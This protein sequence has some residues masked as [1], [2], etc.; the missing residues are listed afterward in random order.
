MREKIEIRSEYFSLAESLDVSDLRAN[1]LN[2]L[3][4]EV[5]G[6]EVDV[7]KILLRIWNDERFSERELMLISFHIGRGA[8]PI[9][10]EKKGYVH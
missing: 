5:I 9:T 10:W 4:D 1:E 6:S 2:S 3:L 7:C 8:H